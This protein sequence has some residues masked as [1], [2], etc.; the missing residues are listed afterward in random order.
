MSRFARRRGARKVDLGPCRCPGTPHQRDEAWVTDQL[1]AGDLVAAAETG[2]AAASARG[3]FNT[4]AR[5]LKY[6]ELGTVRW[7]LLRETLDEAGEVNGAEPAP[8]TWDQVCELD[9]ST[10]DPLLEALEPAI[11]AAQGTVPNGS[12]APSPTSS[13]GSERQTQ[14]PTQTPTTS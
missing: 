11:S 1:G 5:D 2:A 13:P 3:G 10:L 12:G 14:T 6:V 7:N 8:V 4:L 9:R